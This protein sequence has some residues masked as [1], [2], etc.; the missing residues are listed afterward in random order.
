MGVLILF[1]LGGS[2]WAKIDRRFRL[3][4]HYRAIF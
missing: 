3:L 2:L 4:Q 1:I